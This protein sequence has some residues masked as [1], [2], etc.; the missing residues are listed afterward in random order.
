MT[1]EK[2]EAI[3][4][5]DLVSDERCQVRVELNQEAV[6]HYRELY[7]I[8][9]ELPPTEE[10]LLP[11]VEAFKVD[12]KLAGI[13]C[14]HGHGGRF[15]E[16]R[17]T[18][19]AVLARM[20]AAVFQYDMM[21]Y[22]DSKEVGWS[23]KDTPEVLRLQSGHT[24]AGSGPMIRFTNQ[25]DNGTNPNAGEYNLAS[26]WAADLDSNWDGALV[27]STPAARRTLESIT[28]PR[29]G[30]R[31][32]V[33]MPE[34]LHS[35]LKARA[36]KEGRPLSEIVREVNDPGILVNYDA[37]NVMDYLNV[38]PIPDL[39][40]CADVVRS[41]CI[42]DHR[43][44][45]KDQDCGPGL[46]VID[47]YQLLAPVAFTGRVMPLC[48]E[49]IFAPLVARPNQPEGIDALARRAREF[50]LTVTQGLHTVQT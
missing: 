38:D 25:H 28:H 3:D 37:G 18:R 27:F 16:A 7:D 44:W 48:C 34:E 6:K 33:E 22:G 4:I 47:H 15:N 31:M 30:M 17:Q 50:L 10:K 13:L 14:P 45:P 26:I 9:A 35:R 46:G 42:K 40:A 49:N 43:N 11:P 36:K 8:E 41:F 24:A 5:D 2:S 20:G 21:G 29:I 12:G 32:V 19:C 23:H 39:K 1:E